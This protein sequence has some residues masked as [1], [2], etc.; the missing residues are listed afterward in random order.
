MPR[1]DVLS[2]HALPPL[3]RIV[4]RVTSVMVTWQMRR[5]SRR[6]LSRLPDYLLRDVGLDPLSALQEAA[7]PFWRA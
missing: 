6:D 2:S 5:S 4:L 3:S 1:A 7:K